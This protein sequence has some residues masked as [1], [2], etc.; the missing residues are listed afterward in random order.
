MA[1][2]VILSESLNLDC[3]AVDWHPFP[4]HPQP[5]LYL[6]GTLLRQMEIAL[7]IASCPNRPDIYELIREKN[8]IHAPIQAAKNDSAA[9]TNSL[10]T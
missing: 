5:K 9:A 8:R 4:A 7:L 10:G 6:R 2:K 1:V 3:M